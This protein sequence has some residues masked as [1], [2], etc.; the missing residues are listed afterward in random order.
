LIDSIQGLAGGGGSV[1]E[2]VDDVGSV[3]DDVSVGG[4]V[5]VVGDVD[6]VVGA[7]DVDVVV[8]AV[9]DDVVVGAVDDV[10]GVVDVVGGGGGSVNFTRCM[11]S[12]AVVGTTVNLSHSLIVGPP[13]MVYRVKF[14]TLLVIL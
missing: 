10:V 11:L 2:A 14:G 9:D 13:W 5:D 7:V 12:T 3:D 6:V 1:G 8:G 4:A